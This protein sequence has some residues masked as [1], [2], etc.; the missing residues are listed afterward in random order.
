MRST[1]RSA[2]CSCGR[3][4]ALEL[5]VDAQLLGRPR[6]RRRADRRARQGRPPDHRRRGRARCGL[7]PGFGISIVEMGE[8]DRMRWLGFLARIE[9]RADKRVLIGAS[10]A[11]L[12]ELQAALAACGLRR[13]GR[14]R[15]RARSSSSRA[16]RAPR[17][18]R[19]DRRR[20]AAERCVGRR[21]SRALFSARN[22]P[23][24]TLH[25]DARRARAVDR[26]RA[27]VEAVHNVASRDGV[28]ACSRSDHVTP[29][30]R[31]RAPLARW[32]QTCDD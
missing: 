15:S 11:R 21:G 18:R 31:R 29:L 5:D 32:P 2:G 17:R 19:A 14:H 25:G 23:C 13:H 6:R 20:L 22:V 3:N 4:V 7:A 24:V 1:S 27:G 10:P 26:P 8:A 16:R 12:G 9:R 30:L 28:N